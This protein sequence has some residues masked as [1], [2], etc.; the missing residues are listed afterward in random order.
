MNYGSDAM[1]LDDSPDE[2]DEPGDRY[3]VGF[4]GKEMSNFVHWE[5]DRWQTTKPEE[6]KAEKVSGVGSRA[7][8]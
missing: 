6:E 5:P 3:K 1:S 7:D 8:G 2:V 4:D